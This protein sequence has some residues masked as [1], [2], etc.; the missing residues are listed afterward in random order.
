MGHRKKIV[1]IA[2]SAVL[3]VGCAAMAACGDSAPNP[4]PAISALYGA[5]VEGGGT[6]SYDEWYA[7]LLEFAKGF[8]GDKGDKGEQGDPGIAGSDGSSFLHGSGSPTEDVGGKAGDL[9]LDVLTWDVYERTESG[10]GEQP[11]GNIRG[12]KGDKG[13]TTPVDV[14]YETYGSFWLRCHDYKTMPV[15][16]YNAVTGSLRE[17][18]YLYSSYRE[19]GVNFMIGCWEGISIEALNL[20]SDNGIGYFLS[21][22]NPNG[23]Y[24]QNAL[25]AGLAQAMYHDA[26]CG[27]TVVDE[28][29]R[30]RFEG[31]AATQDFLDD[32]MPVSVTGALWWTNLFPNYA[33]DT[34]LYGSDTLPEEM[35]GSYSYEQYVADYMELCKPK[36]LSFDNYGFHV[37]KAKRGAV[38]KDY[39]KNLSVI[40]NAAL[41]AN[42]PFWHFVQDCEFNG[43]SFAP[44]LGELLWA[45]N[46]GLSYGAK[47]IEYF[48]GVKAFSQNPQWAGAMFDFDGSRTDVY[49]LVKTANRQIAA[50]DE[51]LMCS[52]SKGIIVLGELPRSNKKNGGPVSIPAVDQIETYGELVSANAG[53]AIIGCFDYNGKTAFYITN[54][55]VENCD[56]VTLNFGQTVGGFSVL[57]AERREF[58]DTSVLEFS[59]EAG[60][61]VLVV[62]G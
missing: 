30:L 36:V 1:A 33:T 20:C 42:I 5:Y 15:G 12:E 28:P 25:S 10:W 38:R 4:D 52:R 62:I 48:T 51:V 21:P 31:I 47:G 60:E 59:L 54:N 7:D 46:T 56:V 9:Y 16:A 13:D 44:T 19:A 17:S 37:G 27:V 39:F 45:V 6:L 49:N 58:A 41:E 14:T 3:T 24:D 40:R 50:V 53:H 11:I 18:E 43:D 23:N 35:N 34:Q 61:G 55:S 29:S 22:G 57:N 8:K 32:L 2:L 26:F